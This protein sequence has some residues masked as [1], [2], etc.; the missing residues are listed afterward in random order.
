MMLQ[1][2]LYIQLLPHSHYQGTTTFQRNVEIKHTVYYCGMHWHVS[3]VRVCNRRFKGPMQGN[4][5]NSD[6]YIAYCED[7][8]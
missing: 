2:T 5:Q 1:D 8:Y 4:A 3:I 6:D 7:S